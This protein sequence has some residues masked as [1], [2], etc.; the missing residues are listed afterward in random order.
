MSHK[1]PLGSGQQPILI[2]TA[3]ESLLDCHMPGHEL[4]DEL[5]TK[6]K[7]VAKKLEISFAD[8]AAMHG[9]EVGSLANFVVK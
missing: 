8:A 7:S 6:I 2:Q 5:I 4:Y 9:Y 3:G 1:S